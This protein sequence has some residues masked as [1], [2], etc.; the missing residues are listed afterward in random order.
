MVYKMHFFFVFKACNEI[1][2]HYK[3]ANIYCQYLE[4]FLC[5]QYLVMYLT[6]LE[7]LCKKKNI[8]QWYLSVHFFY[9]FKTSKIFLRY[10]Q[11]NKYCTY[12][13]SSISNDVANLLERSV[14]EKI[15]LLCY[16]NTHFLYLFKF[17]KKIFLHSNQPN[18]AHILHV[19]CVFYI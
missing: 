16:L 5:F 3:Q 17:I 7:D 12:L 13:V 19:S 9:S 11:T 6:C 18:I 15:H 2:L 14:W 10:K 8:L 1:F 4:C